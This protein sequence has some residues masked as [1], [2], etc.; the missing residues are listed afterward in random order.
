MPRPEPQVFA[1][2]D[3]PA[4][5]V[6]VDGTWYDGELHA[7]FPTDDGTWVATC[8]WHT[9]PGEQYRGRVDEDHV[10]PAPEGQPQIR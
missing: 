9:A 6:L 4:V 5:E 7:W 8:S 10:R 3:R 2:A 1:P